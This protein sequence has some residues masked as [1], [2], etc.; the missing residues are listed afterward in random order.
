MKQT[1]FLKY[2]AYLQIMGAIL[3][4]FG[5]SFHEYTDNDWVKNILYRMPYS[6]R[7]PLFMFVA[8]FLMIYATKTKPI[9]ERPSATRYISAKMRRLLVP[10]FFLS[11]ITFIPRCLLSDFADDIMSLDVTSF[12][13]SLFFSQSLVITFF[14]FL[15]A[16]FI[17]QVICYTTISKLDGRHER[18]LAFAILL[19]VFTLL[20][21]FPISANGFFA[22]QHVCRL[23]IYFVLG[24]IYAEFG[25]TVDRHVKWTSPLTFLISASL[26]T[27]SFFLFDKTRFIPICSILGIIMCISL[28]RILVDRKIG[29]LDRFIGASYMI[30]LISWYCN[31]FSQQILHSYLPTFPWYFFS[32]LSFLSGIFIPLCL[33]K[34]LKAHNDRHWVRRLSFLLGQKCSG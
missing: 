27:V 14:W 31:V 26:W 11:I 28:S 1:I 22:I 7:M 30:F 18:P 6:F 9:G 21:F 20:L 12:I 4:V 3:V 19:A 10:F 33:Y 29:V 34:W 17:L 2:I 15:Q 16:S 24:S 8:G 23:G 32:I 5:H 25:K 13:K